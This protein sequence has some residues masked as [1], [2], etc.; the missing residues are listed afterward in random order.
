V[1]INWID[2]LNHNYPRQIGKGISDEGPKRGD[3]RVQAGADLGVDVPIAAR[4]PVWNL[5]SLAGFRQ[6]IN[7]NLPNFEQ[8]LRDEALNQ[9]IRIKIFF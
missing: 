2:W 4:K 8:N 3:E 1:L 5:F 7:P 6:R 9:Y